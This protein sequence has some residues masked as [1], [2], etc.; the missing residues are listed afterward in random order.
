MDY[1]LEF[2]NVE[3]GYGLI[4]NVPAG[5]HFF[6]AIDTWGADYGYAAVTQYIYSGITNY[7]Y[8]VIFNS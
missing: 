8:L 6:Q 4:Y 1:N 3:A 2:D 7:V 5:N